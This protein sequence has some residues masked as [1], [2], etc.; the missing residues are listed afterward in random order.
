MEPVAAEPGTVRKILD[1]LT[2]RE[3]R[4]GGL[5]LGM[6]LVLAFLETAG[7]ASVMPFL[8]VLGEPDLVETQPAMAWVY[9]WGRFENVDSFLFALGVG[10]FLMVLLSAAFRIATTY[11]MNRWTQMRRYSI[12]ARL[13][14]TYL[15]QPYEFFLHRNS[16]DLSKSI[17]SETDELALRV[18]RP[19]MNLLAYS[20]VAVV[21][22]GFLI[23]LDPVLA[24]LVA[25]VV[26]GA[27]GL[28]YL[29]VR[30]VL[31]RMGKERVQANRERFTAVSEA[32]GGIKD[33]KVLGREEVYLTR[34]RGPAARFAR[35][36]SLSATL[37]T[38]PKYL[39]EA[40]G[41]GGIL[42]LALALLRTGG[43]LGTVL[44]V[45]GVYAFAGYRLLPSAQNIFRSIS[46]LRF[47]L[48]AVEDVWRETR[49][50][51]ESPLAN[52]KDHTA[53]RLSDCL[54]LE[55]VR[56]RYP[57]ADHDALEALDIDIPAG[58]SAAF[59]GETGAGKTTAIDLILG[60]LRPTDGQVTVDGSPLTEDR[61]RAWQRNIGY[62]PQSIYL[63]DASVAENIA[64]GVTPAQINRDAVRRAAELA[65]IHAFIMDR[66]P[67][68]YDTVI[69]ERGV[70]LSG[71][72]RQ[73]LGI[74][75]ALYHEPDLLVLDEATSALDSQTEASIMKAL[76]RL[77][78]E[79]TIILVAH[80]LSTVKRCNR[81]FLL[82]RGRGIATGSF[83][84]L[85][86]ESDRFRAL[87][88]G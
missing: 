35:Y 55:G 20:L 42:L 65:A 41:F 12:G 24:F 68:G 80:R 8:A 30:G 60:L 28:I 4:T 47:G 16:A 14:A 52:T 23:W 82:E 74:A 78:G 13:L 34:F 75:R 72:Q 53:L 40:V 84:T 33:L 38:V 15:R 1:L 59:I 21:L 22:V 39:I 81:I 64:L 61:V 76:A 50:E 7:V 45:L 29:G 62:V 87:A 18:F 51:Q 9:A 10:A 36:Q 25:T 71:G 44:P 86:R 46:D 32:L 54:R 83:E 3:R 43:E 5:V 77:E 17:L 2:P 63:T 27:Y 26:G 69:G 73:R 57:G 70:R 11:A 49:L 56:F 19:A 6:M 31:G 79:K 58:S 67:N 66:L 48:P 85:S 37:S 88:A